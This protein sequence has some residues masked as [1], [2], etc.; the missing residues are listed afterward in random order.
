MKTM[1]RVTF[2][3]FAAA[4]TLSA[5]AKSPDQISTASVSPTMFSN[6]NCNQMQ[7]EAHRINTRLTEITGRQQSAATGDAIMMGVGLILFWPS[8]FFVGHS[9]DLAPEIAR[10]RGE[11]EAL[12]TAAQAR[13]CVITA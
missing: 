13:N 3:V 5:C 10:L 4:L 7:H 12:H 2:S 1:T 8:L 11:A 9:E 6:L